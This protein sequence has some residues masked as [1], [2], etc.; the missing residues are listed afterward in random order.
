MTSDFCVAVHALVYLNHKGEMLPSEELA[1]NICT[2]PA[3]V[4]K[5]M[6]RLKKAGL[7][8][9]KEGAVGGGYRF[10]GDP[11]AITL[12][13]VADALEVRFVEAAWHS[14]DSNLPC[15]IAS[16]M[17]GLM[18]QVL[19]DLD[20]RCRARLREISITDLDR[21]IF[22]PERLASRSQSTGCRPAL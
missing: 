10:A 8:L 2:N 7:V 9:T 3:R 22:S 4:R 12:D 1:Q 20:S 15:L 19:D 6:S 16:G 21:K 17:A 11:A 5:V 18:D 13:R 14:G